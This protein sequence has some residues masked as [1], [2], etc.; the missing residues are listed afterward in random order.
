MVEEKRAAA[1]AQEENLARIKKE[2]Q[3]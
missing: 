1:Q 2:A 3:E